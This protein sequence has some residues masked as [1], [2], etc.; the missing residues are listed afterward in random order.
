MKQLFLPLFAL[1]F[2]VQS[3]FS[4]DLGMKN[5][6]FE[7]IFLSKPLAGAIAINLNTKKFKISEES[8]MVKVDVVLGDT[9]E[10]SHANTEKY[11]LVM[12]S[13]FMKQKKI[14]VQM[15]QKVVELEAVEIKTLD[16]E[17]MTGVPNYGKEKLSEGQ[18]QL[19]AASKAAPKGDRS[20]LV[21]GKVNVDFIYNWMS[22]K[23][24]ELKKKRSMELKEQSLDYLDLNF[25]DYFIEKL[26]YDSGWVNRLFEASLD[27]KLVHDMIQ[28][29][30]KDAIKIYLLNLSESFEKEKELEEN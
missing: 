24:K 1:L 10:F 20:G 25:S 3:G 15:K 28:D 26:N 21:G 18:R 30:N 17:V 14:E 9:L 22:G 11:L 23:T 13:F 8:G 2:F 27:D 7:I 6:E 16:A 4:Q 29:G 19:N 5:M 12:D